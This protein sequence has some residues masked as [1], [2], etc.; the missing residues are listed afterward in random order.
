MTND[1]LAVAGLLAAASPGKPRQAEL[2]RAVST[3]Y[4]ALF[5]ALAN[6]AA[7]LLVG[8]GKS[9]ATRAWQQTYRALDHGFAKTACSQ[10]RALGFQE[11][12]VTCARNF[13]DLQQRRHS[14]DYDPQH[15]LSRSDALAAIALA[16]T[17]ITALQTTPRPDRRAFAIQLL[18]RRRP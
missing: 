9:R 14:A 12:I 1:F 11:P 8:T 10:A 2:R 4:Y 7:D 3:A 16:E 13:I 17:A 18:L 15:R 5:H 6:D